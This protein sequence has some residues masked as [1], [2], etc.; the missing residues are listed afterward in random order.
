M[1]AGAHLR[2]ERTRDGSFPNPVCTNENLRLVSVD[3]MI[4][5]PGRWDS[6]Q[7]VSVPQMYINAR[8][9]IER[10]FPDHTALL[11]QR[12]QRRDEPGVPSRL[13]TPGGCLEPYEGILAALRREIREETGLE[14]VQ[15]L[16]D[17]ARA[18]DEG[19]DGATECL[20]PYFVYQSLRGP[21]D[22]LGFYFRCRAEGALLERGHKSK[23][24]HWMDVR[25]LRR[26]LN[27]SPEQFNWVDR[28]ALK[29]HLNVQSV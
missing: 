19:P 21:V 3:K 1:A 28:A 24:L 2:V 8:A 7:V 27:G 20:R 12:L 10:E 17:P 9:L 4:W 5:R 14:L 26:L 25:E 13:E 22:S 23:D 16:D 18:V 11:L 29:Y 15:I 6:L